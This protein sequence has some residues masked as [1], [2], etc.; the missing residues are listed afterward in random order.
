MKQLNWLTATSC[1]FLLSACLGHT[2]TERSDDGRFLAAIEA[3]G[4]SFDPADPPIVDF[5]NHYDLNPGT[6]RT[7]ERDRFWAKVRTNYLIEQGHLREETGTDGKTRIRSVYGN[8][9]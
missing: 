2:I 1:F 5:R 7:P 3:A 9:A 4:C 8:C 6:K